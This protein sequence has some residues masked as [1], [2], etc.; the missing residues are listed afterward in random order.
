MKDLNEAFRDPGVRAVFATTGG[1]GS[2]RIID[3][4]DFAA[5]DLDPKPFVGFSDLT[6]VHLARWHRCGVP[7][8][9]GP[10]IAWSDDYYGAVA[11]ERLWRSLMDPHPLVI[12]QDTS[13][14]TA[15]VTTSGVATGIL[16][17]GTLGII[18]SAVGWGCPR[19]EGMILLIEA[20]DQAIGSIDRS[21]TQLI[22]SGFL[23]CV[24]GVAVGQFIRSADPR[25]GKW[26]MVDLLE[27]RL[28]SLGVPILGG[29]PIGHGP[30]PFTV[31]LGTPARLDADRRELTI[32]P[33]VV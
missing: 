33:A 18:S 8:F 15:A 22:R 23:D 3:R 26:S 6:A 16:M 32:Q 12:P 10:H 19:F 4:L 29:L 17:G 7:G 30:A 24:A 20:V 31:P 5:I 1:K 27:D 14:P 21:L 11:A 28:S 2:Y 13:E 25:P 9:H